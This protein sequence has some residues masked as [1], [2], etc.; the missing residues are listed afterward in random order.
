MVRLLC[1]TEN[2]AGSRKHFAGMCVVFH[3]HVNSLKWLHEACFTS[4]QSI[5]WSRVKDDFRF[6]FVEQTR[7]WCLTEGCNMRGRHSLQV[8]KSPATLNVRKTYGTTQLQP[9]WHGHSA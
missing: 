2:C 9:T 1:Y 3:Y 4:D 5:D 8:Q 7:R 6:F